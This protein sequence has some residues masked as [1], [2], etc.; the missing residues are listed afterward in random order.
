MVLKPFLYA[1]YTST[2]SVVKPSYFTLPYCEAKCVNTAVL[3]ALLCAI[4]T[5]CQP[6]GPAYYVHIMYLPQL[7]PVLHF[8]Q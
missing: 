8:T 2:R 4:N 7:F 1:L 3:L 6:P 5:A